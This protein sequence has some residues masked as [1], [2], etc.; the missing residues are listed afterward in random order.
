MNDLV[1]ED[2]TLA[3]IERDGRLWLKASDIA[4]ALGYARADKVSRIY[5]RHKDEFTNCMTCVLETPTLGFSNI[6]SESRCFSLRGAHL[7]GMFA[8]TSKGMAF[9]KWVLDQLDDM[10]QQSK[11]N[12]SLIAEFYKANA[13]LDS[14]NRFASMCGKGLSDHKKIKPP[15]VQKLL[16]ISEKIQPQLQLI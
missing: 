2:K 13:E 5:D 9:R 3:L 1:F 12:H 10:E 4:R 14:Q 11:A 16:Q 8:R 6:T 7:I 15:L